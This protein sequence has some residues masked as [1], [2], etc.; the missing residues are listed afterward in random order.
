MTR[1]LQHRPRVV[2]IVSV[3]NET[4]SVRSLNF[5][6]E[7]SAEA[8]PGQFVMTWVPGADEIPLSLI[9]P[10]DDD[11]V[12]IA[13][14]ERGEGSKSLLRRSKGDM[15]GIRGPYG[16]AF[17]HTNERRVLM[18]AG[19][20]GT[21]PLFALLRALVSKRI[22]CNVILGASTARELL[23]VTEIRSLVGKTEGTVRVATEDGSDG[24][25]GLAT[26]LATKVLKDHSFDRIY[27]CGPE[28]MMRR[29]LDLAQAVQ[30]PVEAGLE[31]I[32]KCGSGICGSCCIGPYLVC[33]EGP[34]F[35]GET[36][37][38]LSEFGVW[39]RDHSGRRVAVAT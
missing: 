18:I 31:R 13:V 27:T 38:G 25:E 23:F 32:F 2:E 17:T 21:V 19:G 10:D 16:S 24:K 39:A 20:T 26:D 35:N 5:K 28:A 8:K 34:V 37:R 6:D 36:L 33:R 12:R 22:E 30:T 11:L 3:K 1:F 29:V 9:P 4:P 15:L 7:L 14:K